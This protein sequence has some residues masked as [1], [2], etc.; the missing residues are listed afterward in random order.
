MSRFIAIDGPDG[1]GKTTV[2][3]GVM[4]VFPDLVRTREPG[5]TQLA[6]KIREVILDPLS[7]SQDPLT[8]LCLFFA[9]RRVHVND[10]VKPALTQGRSVLTDRF[11]TSTF[12]FQVN[13]CDD[14][15]ILELFHTLRSMVLG[16]IEPF[17]IFLDV[18]T[19]TALARL[20]AR[21]GEQTHF[22][23]DGYE[24]HVRRRQGYRRFVEEF[25]IPENQHQFVDANQEPSKVLAD[26]IQIIRPLLE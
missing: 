16:D 17:Y 24:K 3:N 22:D 13:G 11:D 1:A 5:G 10:L 18:D 8:M 23:Q 2:M 15:Q 14:P 19:E 21:K 25:S 9:A 26:V 4:E 12:A 7:S 20:A 6:E